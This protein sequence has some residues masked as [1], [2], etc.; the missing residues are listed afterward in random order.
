MQ[1]DVCL[2]TFTSPA[3]REIIQHVHLLGSVRS[4]HSSVCAA[5]VP[6][7]NNGY[8]EAEGINLISSLHLLDAPT[9]QV[10]SPSHS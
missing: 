3:G 1:D 7:S 6:R 9:L 5:T 2:S 10:A 8:R 4:P